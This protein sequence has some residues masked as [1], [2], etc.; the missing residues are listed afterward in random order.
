MKYNMAATV[1]AKQRICVEMGTNPSMSETF[2]ARYLTDEK[3]QRTRKEPAINVRYHVLGKVL[4]IVIFD[5]SQITSQLSG[6][7]RSEPSDS[8]CLVRVFL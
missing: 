1:P 2:I 6:G 7:E 8:N 3:P 5:S 4:S